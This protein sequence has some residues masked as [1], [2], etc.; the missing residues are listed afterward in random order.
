MKT[1]IICIITILSISCSSSKLIEQYKSPD[2]PTFEAN[3]ILIIGMAQNI[4]SRRMFEK[5]LSIALE[6]KDVIAV[7]SVDFFENSFASDKKS[8]TD[9]NAIEKQLTDAGFDAII[10]S[11]VISS[12][13]K[14]TLVKAIKNFDDSFSN[15]REDY[16]KSQDIYF[17]Q[18][19]LQESKI[20]HTETTL[21]CICPTKERELIWKGSIDIINPQKAKA[22]IGDYVSLLIKEFEKQQLLMVE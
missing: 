10:L 18:D 2:N 14:I 21:Y 15:F 11:K 19:Y 22:S 1:I 12:E 9:L 5:E 13:N 20:F 8:E 6:K 7:K 16:Y 17:N 3:K 4:E